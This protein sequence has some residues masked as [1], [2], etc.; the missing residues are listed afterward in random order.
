M[1]TPITPIL[2][3]GAALLLAVLVT[4]ARADIL[5]ASDFAF[6]TIEKITSGGVGSL[7]VNT[8]TNGTK[9][10]A[11]DSAGNLYVAVFGN[12]I[13]KYTPG[14]ISSV[15][16]STGSS[17]AV[18]LAFDTAGNLY[19]AYSNNTIEKFTIGGVG[20]VFAST[21]LSNPGGIAFDRTG[22]LYV[23]NSI[24][25]TIEKF[26]PT[27][28]DLG[29]FASLPSHP[30][31]LAFDRAGNLYVS[32]QSALIEKYTPGG[33]GSVFAIGGGSAGLAFDSADNLYVAGGGATV[34]NK[35]TPGGVGS[36]FAD[37]A[38]GLGNPAFLAFTN[39][40]GVPLSLPI[41]E[42]AS[43]ALLGLGALL[44]AARRRKA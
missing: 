27:G 35:F 6:A 16:A 5:Y 8:P 34:I 14:G 24:S 20:S 22:N 39:D 11:F 41:P 36:V 31:G 38:D 1:K 2:T 12:S 42:P 28:T 26:S 40:A 30:Y 33:V 7:F 23:A 13:L 43:A 25:D 32:Y 17:T 44:L 9:G 21:G 18:G 10:I 3:S 37:A 15:F 19:A 29:V 4:P